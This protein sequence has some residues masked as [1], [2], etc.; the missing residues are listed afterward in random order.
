MRIRDSTDGST[1]DLAKQETFLQPKKIENV[2]YIITYATKVFKL[3]TSPLLFAT[4]RKRELKIAPDTRTSI[5]RL[6]NNEPLCLGRYKVAI[7]TDHYRVVSEK[8]G[9]GWG[10]CEPTINLLFLFC[11]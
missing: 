6:V 7:V 8:R 4:C 1:G 3:T 5:L 2:G 11:Q 10:Q 9:V